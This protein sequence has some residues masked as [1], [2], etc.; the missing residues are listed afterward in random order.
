MPGDIANA[1][2]LAQ[3]AYDSPY[4]RA[5]APSLHPTGDPYPPLRSRA[6]STLENM[7][8]D[9]NTLIQR[10]V[11]WAEDQDPF[12]HVRQSQFMHFLGI[13][14]HRTMESYGEFLTEQEYNDMILSKTVIPVVRKYKLE[15][16]QQVKYPDSLIVANRPDPEVKGSVTF[17][18]AAT[19]QP[20]DIRSVSDGW[21]K[22]YDEYLK[23]VEASQGI[24]QKWDEIK[25]RTK[26]SKP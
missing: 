5:G 22:V 21:V 17:I 13:G 16:R 4:S 9:P 19:G 2:R 20:I 15:I 10:G 3:S 1:S 24:K 11:L 7:G 14:F 18:N 6:L 23:R 25:S 8:Y 12:R 26:D